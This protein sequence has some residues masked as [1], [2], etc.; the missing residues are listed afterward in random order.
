MAPLPACPSLAD[1]RRLAGVLIQPEY[2]TLLRYKGSKHK[3]LY[4]WSVI[5]MKRTSAST[6]CRMSAICGS[7]ADLHGGPAAH[8]AGGSAEGREGKP[9]AQHR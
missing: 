2:D 6:C 9:D 5:A 4:S 8:H 1:W 7:D 3:L